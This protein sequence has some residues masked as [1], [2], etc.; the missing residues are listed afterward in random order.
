M[1]SDIRPL[2]DGDLMTF[3]KKFFYPMYSDYDVI[4][5]KSSD[6]IAMQKLHDLIFNFNKKKIIVIMFLK[7]KSDYIKVGHWTMMILPQN[8]YYDAAHLSSRQ[9]KKWF[10]IPSWFCNNIKPTNKMQLQAYE[11][12]VCGYWL[13]AF[14]VI[15]FDI[16]D[17][18]NPKKF[19]DYLVYS[20][21]A[22]GKHYDLPRENLFKLL[23]NYQ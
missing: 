18:H 10:D 11:D 4:E 21:G 14:I 20:M 19:N 9:M 6:Q 8:H 7:P 1:E 3:F 22:D 2:D 23:N 15:I 17:S 16:L 5:I 13:E 12:S